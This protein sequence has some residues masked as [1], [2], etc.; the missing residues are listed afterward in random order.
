MS[1]ILEILNKKQKEWKCENLILKKTNKLGPKI[2]LS[3]PLM[4]YA[5]YGGLPR[6]RVIE[7]YGEPGSGKSSTA[8]DTCKTAYQ[9]F[10][11]EHNERMSAL[12]EKLS[13]GD[14]AAGVQLE[15]LE[16]LG[17]KE[18]LYFDVEHAF[19]PAWAAKLGVDIDEVKV[20]QPPNVSAEELLQMILDIIQ[21]GNAGLVVIDS[22]PSLVP[23][24]VID[25]KIGEKTVAAL[26][27]LM[28]TFLYKVI[29]LLTRYDCTL[30]FIN[31]IRPNMDNPWEPNT[32]GGEAIKFYAS[33]RIFFRLGT[34]V[35]FL[36]NELPQKTENPAGYIVSAKI[37]KQKTAPW[38]RKV[39]SYYLM[40][41]SGIR[42]DMDF[43]Q[44][45]VKKYEIIKKS[46]AWFTLSNPTTGEILLDDSGKA[47]KLNGFAKVIEYVRENPDYFEDLKTYIMNDIE[48]NGSDQLGQ[49]Q[50]VISELVDY[51]EQEAVQQ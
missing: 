41:Q 7:F 44:L 25:K 51:T 24:A 32:P 3:S 17:P 28:T 18:V 40:T 23:K 48:G 38:D 37:T 34:P 20:I 26:A 49:T 19:D 46:G 47:L 11:R 29:P 4:N 21:E 10:E 45:A 15:E 6:G 35:D 39:G 36:G 2:P 12:R 42:P 16:E 13:K 50:E 27:G 22:V 1:T 43:C 31:Q 5:T 8:V 30:L 9:T 14:K 33:L